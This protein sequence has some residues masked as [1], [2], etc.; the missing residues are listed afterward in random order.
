MMSE[1]KYNVITPCNWK[2]LKD[3]TTSIILLCLVNNTL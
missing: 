3:M 2:D 1:Y